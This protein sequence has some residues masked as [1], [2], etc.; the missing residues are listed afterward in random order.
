VLFVNFLVMRI[1]SKKQVST[2]LYYEGQRPFR[3]E[4]AHALP[5]GQGALGG[6][7]GMPNGR[8]L[9]VKERSPPV[10]DRAGWI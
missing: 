1:L 5:A 3:L 7:S 8:V 10:A 4:V 6:I 9:V 2:R